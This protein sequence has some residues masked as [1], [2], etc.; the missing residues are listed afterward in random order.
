MYSWHRKR[1]ELS[2][3][4]ILILHLKTIIRLSFFASKITPL[5]S[6][7]RNSEGDS[8]PAFSPLGPVNSASLPATFV[9]KMRDP[10]ILCYS[11][12]Q[13]I[14]VIQANSTPSTTKIA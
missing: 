11:Y 1:W 7:S 9:L 10:L 14:Q 3:T 4:G 6:V 12:A 5:L 8:V 13:Q 2:T